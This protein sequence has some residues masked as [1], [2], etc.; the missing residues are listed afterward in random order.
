MKTNGI[1]I[2][3]LWANEI[4][5]LWKKTVWKFCEHEKWDE[6]MLETYSSPCVCES[7][8]SVTSSNY[9]DYGGGKKRNL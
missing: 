6:H 1:G 7:K 8:Q 4:Q 3:A 5:T 9:G 2:S